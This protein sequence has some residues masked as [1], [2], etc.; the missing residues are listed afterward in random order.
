MIKFILGVSTVII[1]IAVFL[2]YTFIFSV[3]CSECGKNYNIAE[4]RKCSNCG[5]VNNRYI[6]TAIAHYY[7]VLWIIAAI[8]GS[9]IHLLRL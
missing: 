6:F 1:P 8:T 4:F 3:K 9:I 5:K 7:W 2:I